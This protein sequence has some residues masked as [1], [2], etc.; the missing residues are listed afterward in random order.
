MSI[1]AAST[2]GYGPLELPPCGILDATVPIDACPLGGVHE[3]IP[4]AFAG[5]ELFSRGRPFRLDK[6]GSLRADLLIDYRITPTVE[7]ASMKGVLIPACLIFTFALASAPAQQPQIRQETADA[8]PALT[9]EMWFYKQQIDRYDNPKAVVRRNAE[10]Q[11][12]Q[13]LA[14]ME[15]LKWYGFSNA[16]PVASPTPFTSMYSPAWQSNWHRPYAW[17]TSGRPTIVV[18]GRGVGN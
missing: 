9:P 1:S 14:R 6:W 5:V 7:D 3:S 8:E 17:Y 11:H 4:R 15:A 18:T 2:L 13:R 12:Q 16:R 10:F